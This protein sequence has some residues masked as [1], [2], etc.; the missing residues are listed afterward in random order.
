MKFYVAGK[1]QDRFAVQKIHQALIDRGHEITVD[2]TNHVD[3]QN[4]S[5][6]REWSERDIEGSTQCDTYIGVFRRKVVYTG[7]LVEM[8]AALAA[9]RRV[10]II[11]NE[12]DSCIFM[13]HPLVVKF[14]SVK[15]ML[16]VLDG[17][18]RR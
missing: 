11:G 13:N 9:G 8:G 18:P 3:P 1:W 4:Q 14:P 17:I 6:L 15:T 5:I 10:W 7:A 16:R 2:W 12:I